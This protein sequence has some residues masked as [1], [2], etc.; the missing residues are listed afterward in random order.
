MHSSKIKTFLNNESVN[1]DY[2]IYNN[3]FIKE[4]KDINSVKSILVGE[5]CHF[6][7]F[8]QFIIN[9]K[10]LKHDIHFDDYNIHLRLFFQNSSIANIHYYTIDNN[11][12]SK[13]NIIIHN[14]DTKIVLDNFMDL[15][16][17]NK[18]KKYNFKTNKIDKGFKN[19]Y[20]F[21]K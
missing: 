10:V 7:D 6:I 21:F 1:I 16:V 15:M 20:I 13:E 3:S 18:Y 17:I 14:G 5:I 8:C 12:L 11:N 4:K 19:L 2:N 9:K